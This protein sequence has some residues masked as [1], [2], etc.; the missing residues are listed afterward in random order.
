MTIELVNDPKRLHRMTVSLG[1]SGAKFDTAMH[2]IAFNALCLAEN[3][4]DIRPMQAL[5]DVLTPNNRAALAV[6]AL[7]FGKF[8]YDKA[9]AKFKFRKSATTQRI[10]AEGISP[11]SYVKAKANKAAPEFD[12]LESLER[13]IAKG[14]KAECKGKVWNAI[15]AARQLAL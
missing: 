14:R 11:L 4:G 2:V 13:L 10:E 5:H 7:A 8:S 3:V 6:W 15:L 12:L 1:K 9:E